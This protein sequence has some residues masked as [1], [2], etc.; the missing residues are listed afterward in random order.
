MS[1]AEADYL[2]KYLVERS[3]TPVKTH[4]EIVAALRENHAVKTGSQAAVDAFEKAFSSNKVSQKN[5]PIEAQSQELSR[6]ILPAGK[7]VRLRNIINVS[8]NTAADEHVFRNR[9]EIKDI[10]YDIAGG[11]IRFD[12]ENRVWKTASHQVIRFSD[13]ELQLVDAIFQKYQPDHPFLK[14]KKIRTYRKDEEKYSNRQYDEKL[15]RERINFYQ[16]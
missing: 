6:N 13:S 10:I 9:P 3:K 12:A 11:F 8:K 4:E 15:I 16:Q 5:I 14:N 2:Q 1:L 7:F